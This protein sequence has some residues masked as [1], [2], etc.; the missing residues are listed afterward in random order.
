L[1][2]DG[3]ASPATLG[4]MTVIY[5]DLIASGERTRQVIADVAAALG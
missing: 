3:P 1:I 5:K 2:R 4:G